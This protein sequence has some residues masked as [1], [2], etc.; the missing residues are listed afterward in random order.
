MQWNYFVAKYG[1]SLKVVRFNLRNLTSEDLHKSLALISHLE[2]LES[3]VME[4]LSFET[5]VKPIDEC[6]R[7]LANNCTKL[8]NLCLKT[9]ES[10]LMSDNIFFSL[11]DFRSLERLVFNYQYKSGHLNRSVECLKNMTRL[12]NLSIIHSQLT[13]DFFANIQTILPN[14]QYLFIRSKCFTDNSIKAFTESLQTMKYLERVVINNK[15][16]YYRRIR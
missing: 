1:K 15:K 2:S 6:I 10:C 5:N 14:L 3:L 7:L 16:F 4:I 8:R 11:S 9:N 13:K 12:N